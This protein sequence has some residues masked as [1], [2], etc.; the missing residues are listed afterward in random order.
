[1]SPCQ[2]LRKEGDRLILDNSQQHSTLNSTS[3]SLPKYYDVSY[4]SIHH[5]PYSEQLRSTKGQLRR[6]LD[7]T[8]LVFGL[9]Q[10][11]VNTTIVQVRPLSTG[12]NCAKIP[13]SIIG[14][15]D[16]IRGAVW[17]FLK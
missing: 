2:Q 10:V 12:L 5:P 8:G 14:A 3:P 13:A 4:E 11:P 9:G 7:S 1:M 6:R 17:S 16:K 15:S